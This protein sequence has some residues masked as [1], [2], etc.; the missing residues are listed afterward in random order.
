MHLKL[1][2]GKLATTKLGPTMSKSSITVTKNSQ[3]SRSLKS[4]EALRLTTT[5]QEINHVKSRESP[6]NYSSVPNVC[7]VSSASSSSTSSSCGCCRHDVIEHNNPLTFDDDDDDQYS[8]ASSC[9]SLDLSQSSLEL[10]KR[11]QEVYCNK[12]VLNT[13]FSLTILA[14]K[15]K[16]VLAAARS[17]AFCRRTPRPAP[18]QKQQQQQQSQA[19]LQMRLLSNQP[20][21]PIHEHEEEFEPENNELLQF[22]LVEDAHSQSP[23]DKVVNDDAFTGLTWE[24]VEEALAQSPKDK[25]VNDDSFTGLI[26]KTKRKKLAN[27]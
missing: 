25:I 24:D 17:F 14:A 8:F 4:H 9:S 12:L 13:N 20:L 22:K 21:R 18:Q 27:C 10:Q 3:D 7:K 1:V 16:A 23:A 6:R 2:N 11:L 26:F 19:M 15:E 5:N